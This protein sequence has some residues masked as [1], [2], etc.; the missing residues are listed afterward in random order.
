MKF[1]LLFFPDGCFTC[2]PE[3]YVI[4][5]PP[6]EYDKPD[7][8]AGHVL[9]THE[10][11]STEECSHQIDLLIKDLEKLK[12]VAKSKFADNTGTVLEANLGN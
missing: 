10:T 12:L 1:D 3:A 9:L 5:T 4:A 8:R 6:G 11:T 7:L 2:G